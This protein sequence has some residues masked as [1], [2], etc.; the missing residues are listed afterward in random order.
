MMVYSKNVNL[1]QDHPRVW[2]IYGV[3]SGTSIPLGKSWAALSLPR[4]NTTRF[5]RDCTNLLHLISLLFKLKRHTLVDYSL[6][7]EII[8]GTYG[9]L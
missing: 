5:L 9:P 6:I 2:N 1:P 4:N 7:L 3:A 8:K